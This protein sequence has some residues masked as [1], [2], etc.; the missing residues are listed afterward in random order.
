MKAIALFKVFGPNCRV[1]EI[2]IARLNEGIFKY[3]IDGQSVTWFTSNTTTCAH[4]IQN[5]AIVL[6]KMDALKR[7]A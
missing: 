4:G 7:V 1:D 6:S 2:V 5:N 3:H